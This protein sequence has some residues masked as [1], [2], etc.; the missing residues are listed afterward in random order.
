MSLLPLLKGSQFKF[1]IVRINNNS[2]WKDPYQVATIRRLNLDGSVFFHWFTKEMGACYAIDLSS[3]LRCC[4]FLFFHCGHGVSN[5][6][7]MF[8]LLILGFFL[9]YVRI[10]I[11]MVSQCS[12]CL[13]W[14]CNQTRLISMPWYFGIWFWFLGSLS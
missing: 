5:W 11:W 1:V 2:C 14:T 12:F 4:V 9:L 7:H 8:D 10:V 13:S 3:S 6:I